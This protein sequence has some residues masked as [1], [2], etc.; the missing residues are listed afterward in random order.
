MGEHNQSYAEEFFIETCAANYE[1]VFL[2]AIEMKSG[3]M[4]THMIAAKAQKNTA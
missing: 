1:Q 4:S 2:K 3:Q